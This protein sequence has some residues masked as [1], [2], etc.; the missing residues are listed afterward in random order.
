MCIWDVVVIDK[1][2]FE[3]SLTALQ[4][5]YRAIKGIRFP[6]SIDFIGG[7]NFGMQLANDRGFESVLQT[8][9]NCEI[10]PNTHKKRQTYLHANTKLAAESTLI[11]DTK[12]HT[13]KQI[14][15]T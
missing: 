2:A 4:A 8:N 15:A 10:D 11:V 1:G 5:Q 7:Q 9:R 3:Y 12:Q 14:V 6:K 13:T